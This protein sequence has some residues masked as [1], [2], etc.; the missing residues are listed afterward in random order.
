MI[1]YHNAYDTASNI[2]EIKNITPQNR[3]TMQFFCIGCGAKM[4][5]VLGQKKQHHF[6][7]KDKD[8]CRPETY[9]HRLAKQILK[10]RFNTEPQ[11]LVKY[12]VQNECSKSIQCDL[13]RRYNWND[14][15]SVVLK[16]VNL[17]DYYDTCEEE[18]SYKGFR[19]DLMLTHSEYPD[20]KPVFLEVAVTHDCTPEKI[21]SK[22]RIIEIKVQ[23]EV[24]ASKEIVENEGE[25]V[26]QTKHF[27]QTEAIIH[28]IR[29][30]NFK[31]KNEISHQIS[32]FD[33]FKSD[34]GIFQW[35]CNPNAVTCQDADRKYEKNACFSVT[36]SKDKIPDQKFGKFIALGIALSD[37]R[38]FKIKNCTFCV[39][40]KTCMVFQ[41]STISTLT[42]SFVIQENFRINELSLTEIEELRLAYQCPK[43]SPDRYFFNRIINIFNNIPYR[44]C[45]SNENE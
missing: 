29:F 41:G 10:I 33:L 24:D 1:K 8:N 11:F 22:I 19:A 6:R 42:E 23:G 20:R 26:L 45:V 18:I 39:H 2:V 7:H 43:Y 4:E 9:Y 37:K 44:E 32:R 13:K 21:N 12:Y 30:Y 3:M 31:R 34:D 5:A 28:P 15:S 16:M 17:K 25:F 14:C 40:Y 27:K 36:I 38:G 35:K